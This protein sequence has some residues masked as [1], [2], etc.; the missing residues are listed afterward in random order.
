MEQEWQRKL[1]H[2]KQPK[3]PFGR[4]PTRT[5][6]NTNNTFSKSKGKRAVTVKLA[7]S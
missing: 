3:T 1:V 6:G 5:L 4:S 2:M 7:D